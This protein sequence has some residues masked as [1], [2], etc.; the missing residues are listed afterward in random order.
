MWASPF[1]PLLV[2]HIRRGDLW[3]V[4]LASFLATP[5]GAGFEESW[6]EIPCERDPGV[7]A[8]EPSRK[9]SR[10]RDLQRSAKQIAPDTRVTPGHLT[11][12]PGRERH[13]VSQKWL[14]HLATSRRFIPSVLPSRSLNCQPQKAVWGVREGKSSFSEGF[15]KA[16]PVRC[17]VGS[18]G[19]DTPCSQSKGS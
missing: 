14:S 19:G 6:L 13:G 11:H 15:G 16:G 3:M 18:S 10:P 9:H 7:S 8:G 1:S 12:K 2:C 4:G 5:T 17:C